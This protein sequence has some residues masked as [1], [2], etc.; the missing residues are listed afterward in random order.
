MDPNETAD[1]DAPEFWNIR[2]DKF[3]K[4]KWQNIVDDYMVAF[5]KEPE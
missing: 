2:S 3:T 1:P 4:G 5:D